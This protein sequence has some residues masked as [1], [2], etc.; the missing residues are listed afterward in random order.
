MHISFKKSLLAYFHQHVWSGV[1]GGLGH[2]WHTVLIGEKELGGG[3][4]GG[5]RDQ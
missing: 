5:V 2:E 1:K 3:W 4:E